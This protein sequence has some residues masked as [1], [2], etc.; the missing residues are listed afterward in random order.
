VSY[1]PTY[2]DPEYY[3]DYDAEEGD[4]KDMPSEQEVNDMADS[5]SPYVTV[6]S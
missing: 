3:D 2:E 4:W 1:R 5:Y 6:N